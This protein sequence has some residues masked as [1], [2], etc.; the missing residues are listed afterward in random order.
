MRIS[1]W[2]SDVCSSD[3]PAKPAANTEFQTMRYPTND[4]E[5]YW[6]P[7]TSNKDFKKHPRLLVEGKGVH[8]KG[9]DGH[10]IVDAVSGLFCSPAGHSRP[11]IAE[12]VYEPLQELSYAPSFQ[13]SHPAAFELA[14]QV[15]A[16]TPGRSDY[17][18]FANSGS[19]AV[20]TALKI[21]ILYHRVR[22]EGQRLRLVG[23]ERGY[24]GVNFTGF[25]IGSAVCRERVGQYV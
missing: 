11:E 19:E 16:L 9:H 15:K 24:H 13:H 22:G 8:Y 6:L 1:D 20:K 23:R 21:A 2:S 3:L 10:D 12:A 25:Y 5:H 17:I 14:R 7:F 18:F 4:L